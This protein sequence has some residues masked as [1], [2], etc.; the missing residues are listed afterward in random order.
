MVVVVGKKKRKKRFVY[1]FMSI[2]GWT[3]SFFWLSIFSYTNI[4]H[5]P[6][7]DCSGDTSVLVTTVNSNPKRP[8]IVV[9]GEKREHAGFLSIF[10]RLLTSFRCN[11]FVRDGSLR[12]NRVCRSNNNYHVMVRRNYPYQNRPNLRIERRRT[13]FETDIS[14]LL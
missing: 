12:S 3:S 10:S 14:S 2:Y 11:I 9:V 8:I 4:V 13:V 1:V 5:D 6:S 7:I